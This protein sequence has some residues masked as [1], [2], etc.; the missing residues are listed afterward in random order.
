VSATL[1]HLTAVVKPLETTTPE[2]LSR[3]QLAD[4]LAEG[5][6][7]EQA[8]RA[9]EEQMEEVWEVLRAVVEKRGRRGEERE[10]AFEAEEWGFGSGA[11][12]R[13]RGMGRK[14]IF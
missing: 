10:V 14:R 6:Y 5:A 3:S 13:E 11:R 4:M 9:F 7:L 2:H 12:A 1:A 8:M